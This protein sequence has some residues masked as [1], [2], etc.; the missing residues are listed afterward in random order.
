MSDSLDRINWPVTTRR[1]LLR[2]LE[3]ADA[4]ATWEYRKL[5]EVQRWITSCADDFP[6]Y[7]EQFM[8]AR[9]YACDVAVQL[10]DA[11]GRP[12][13]IG[14]VMVKVKDG[15]GQ[16]E[17]EDATRGVEAE[18]GWSLNPEYGGLG[19]ATEAV[20]GVI[21][22]CFGQLGLRRVIAECFAANEPSWR[23]MERIGMRR[24]GY[25]KRDA[26]HRDGQWLDGMGYALL[27]EEWPARF[28]S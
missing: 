22:L 21:D 20:C 27:A 24:E 16:R 3:I 19:Y 2:R 17:I 25:S 13:L 12:Q 23:L 5:P 14:T 8:E 28:E 15:W 4:Q 6:Q 7:L 26:L 1:L 18:I 9:R 10:L 11:Q